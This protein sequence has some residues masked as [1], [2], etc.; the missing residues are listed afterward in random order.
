MDKTSKKDWPNVKID[1]ELHKKIRQFCLNQDRRIQE[2]INEC[3]T[4]EKHVK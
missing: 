2:F 3:L 4:T 1:P